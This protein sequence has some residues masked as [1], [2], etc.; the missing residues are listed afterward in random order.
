MK[1]NPFSVRQPIP[2]FALPLL[3]GDTEPAVDL[4]TIVHDLYTRARF[5]LRLDYTRPAE[6]P[7]SDDDAA[8]ARELI[9]TMP[10]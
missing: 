8:W 6:P 3:P 5:D 1:P 2:S 4:N 7:L 10:R 9:D